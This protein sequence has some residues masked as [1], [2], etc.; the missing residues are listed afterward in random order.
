MKKLI[1]AL[2]IAVSIIALIVYFVRTSQI[3]TITDFTGLLLF[4]PTLLAIPGLLF[5]YLANKE[6][7]GS[8]AIILIICNVLLLLSIPFIHFAG[9]LMLGV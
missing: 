9:T 5:A 2:C 1:S 4:V 6:R 3:S 8:F 7:K